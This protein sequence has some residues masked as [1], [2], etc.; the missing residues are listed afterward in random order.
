MG[1]P[2]FGGDAEKGDCGCAKPV[3]IRSTYRTC[4]AVGLGELTKMRAE[5]QGLSY[6][7]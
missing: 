7:S 1:T 6:G 4:S 3:G 5:A 2:D